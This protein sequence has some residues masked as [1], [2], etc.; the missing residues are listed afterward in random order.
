MKL[1]GTLIEVEAYGD[2]DVK[3]TKAIMY[4]PEV[5]NVDSIVSTY[6]SLRGLDGTSGLPDNMISDATDDFIKY[7]KK[8]GFSEISGKKVY[9]CD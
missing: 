3:Y 7:L 1:P 5:R 9:F 4:T 2:F 8:E 6:C